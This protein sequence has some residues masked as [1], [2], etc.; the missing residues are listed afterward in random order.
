MPG[1]ISQDVTNPSQVVTAFNRPQE[2]CPV[3]TLNAFLK[4]VRRDEYGQAAVLNTAFG[5]FITGI[6]PPGHISDLVSQD[7]KRGGREN[8]RGAPSNSISDVAEEETAD[9]GPKQ[10]GT[11]HLAH[12]ESVHVQRRRHIWR[13]ESDYVHVETI[14]KS[15]H[16]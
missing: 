11:E 10:P 1:V 15:H 4:Q 9:H 7:A 2:P 6:K 5:G 14:E 13:D 16:P 8:D 3:T 12:H